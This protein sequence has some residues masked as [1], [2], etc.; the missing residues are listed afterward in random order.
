MVGSQ[1][2]QKNKSRLVGQVG[3]ILGNCQTL[4]GIKTIDSVIIKWQKYRTF[5][6][7]A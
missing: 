4:S 7:R 5:D 6:F 2:H 1:S 3:P